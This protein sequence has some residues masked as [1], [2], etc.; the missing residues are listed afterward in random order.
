MSLLLPETD[1]DEDD[2]DDA[3]EEGD[4]DEGDSMHTPDDEVDEDK[5][6][7]SMVLLFLL[8]PSLAEVADVGVDVA[9]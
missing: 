3:C 7:D 8:T 6:M 5:S 4:A 1:D 2:D 9:R